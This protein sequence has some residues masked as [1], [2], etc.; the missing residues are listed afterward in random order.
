MKIF[1]HHSELFLNYHFVCFRNK[2]FA[3]KL[4]FFHLALHYAI[5]ILFATFFNPE[6]HKS[7]GIHEPVGNCESTLPVQTLLKTLS[8][9]EFLCTTD[10][11]EKYFNFNCATVPKEGSIWYTICGTA[12]D[13]R[14]EY[15]WMSFI[16]ALGA[17]LIFRAIHFDYDGKLLKVLHPQRGKKKTN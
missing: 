12:F 11:D 15:V 3:E 8:K 17:F 1:A 7:V 6:S 16:I 9:K 2:S 4:L 14:A 5:Y 13:N 10:Y